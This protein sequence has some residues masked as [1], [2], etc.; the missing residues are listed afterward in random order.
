MSDIIYTP[1]ASSGGTTINPTNNVIPVR[2]NATT[3]VD[4]YLFSNA[5][6]LKSVTNGDGKGIIL[7]FLNDRYSLGDPDIVNFGSYITVDNLNSVINLN[8]GDGFNTRVY[9]DDT[10]RFIK[11][12]YTGN[13]IGL[14]L[15]FNNLAYSF[16]DFNVVNNGTRLII[17]D[18]SLKITF[19]T[20]YLNFNGGSLQSN[21]A[22]GNSGEHLVIT[23]NGTQYKIQLLNP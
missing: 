17:D 15:D 10:N 3:F 23:L 14:Q 5:T 18:N 7:D 13:D 20:N 11:T 21:T 1:P 8:G 19:D 2:S 4:S 22:S 16:G 6:Q 9:I 12:T